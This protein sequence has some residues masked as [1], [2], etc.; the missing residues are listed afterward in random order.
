MAE[1]SRRSRSLNV[2]DFLYEAFYSGG[3]GGAVVALCFL[4]V[5]V[6]EGHPLFTPS[7]MGSVLFEGVPAE[8]VT[9][10]RL[11]MVAYYSIVHMAAFGAL[12][13]LVTFLVHEVE[14]HARHPILVLLGLFVLFEAAFV[15]AAS[16]MLPGV[17]ER[18]GAGWVAL[19][20]FLA[21]GA[22]AIFLLISHRPEALQRRGADAQA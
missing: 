2:G 8:S 1:T 16:F 3:L 21:A 20:N 4:V 19:A 17:I 18:L 9:G 10:V 7:M 14:L 22:I 6:F 15:V 13:A 11:E 12:G 5:D